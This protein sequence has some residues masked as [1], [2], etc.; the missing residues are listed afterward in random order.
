MFK[1]L[2]HDRQ[3][4]IHEGPHIFNLP[5]TDF[6]SEKVFSLILLLSFIHKNIVTVLNITN[7]KKKHFQRWLFDQNHMKPV[8]LN[9]YIKFILKNVK[10]LVIS[11]QN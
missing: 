9:K 8:N 10:L 1:I 4:I 6:L 5:V 3:P 11:K 2:F 7:L